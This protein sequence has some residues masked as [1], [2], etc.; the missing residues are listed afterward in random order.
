VAMKRGV[1]GVCNLTELSECAGCK[2]VDGPEM[3]GV[4][5]C[6]EAFAPFI[7]HFRIVEFIILKR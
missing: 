7:W 2:D 5:D 3:M 6:V 4:A 1:S